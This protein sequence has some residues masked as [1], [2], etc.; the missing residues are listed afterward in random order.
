MGTLESHPE[1]RMMLKLFSCWQLA[2]CKQPLQT[3][4]RNPSHSGEGWVEVEEASWEDSCKD[5][6]PALGLVARWRQGHLVVTAKFPW[7]IRLLNGMRASGP[8][9]GGP[10][11]PSYDIR[12]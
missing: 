1:D 11:L 8:P 3:Q 5:L 7:D 6:G 10:Q 2:S 4:T 9:R 12:L